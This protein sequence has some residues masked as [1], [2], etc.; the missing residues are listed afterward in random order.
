MWIFAGGMG[1]YVAT[2]CVHYVLALCRSELRPNRHDVPLDYPAV[3]ASEC[4]FTPGDGLTS[5]TDPI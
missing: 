5:G 1:G 4:V 3:L 2:R